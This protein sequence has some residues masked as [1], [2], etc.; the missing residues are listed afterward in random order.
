MASKQIKFDVTLYSKEYKPSCF[1]FIQIKSADDKMSSVNCEAERIEGLNQIQDDS[2][3]CTPESG[4]EKSTPQHQAVELDNQ[5]KKKIK[6]REDRGI[7]ELGFGSIVSSLFPGCSFQNNL[8]L[9]SS[10]N[11]II[12]SSSHLLIASLNPYSPTVLYIGR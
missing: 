1:V 10:A 9:R 8:I 11:I 3:E 12:E 2:R 4:S 6:K 5:G 7:G